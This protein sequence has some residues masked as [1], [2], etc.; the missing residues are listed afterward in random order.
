[1]SARTMDRTTHTVQPPR[2]LTVDTP[3]GRYLIAAQHTSDGDAVTGVWREQQKHFPRAGRLGEQAEDGDTLLAEASRQLLQ[4]LAGER[5]GFDLPLRAEGTPF[6]LRVWEQLRAIPYG[7]T[8]TYGTLAR[9]LGAP[10]ASQAVGAAVGANPLSIL[11]PCHR[12]VAADGRLT[13]YAG[14][15]GTKQALLGLEGALPR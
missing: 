7:G 15:L 8:T 12:V 4:Y 14:G 1:M 11:V 3:V 10:R 13:G 6:Q 2:H 5:E 9:E